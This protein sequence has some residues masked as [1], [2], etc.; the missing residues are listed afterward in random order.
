MAYPMTMS[1]GE[2]TRVV[3]SAEQEAALRFD[4]WRADT[5]PAGRGDFLPPVTAPEEPAA[6]AP[7]ESTKRRRKSEPTTPSS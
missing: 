2:H 5:D 6:D 4:G 3:M 1:K 7:D